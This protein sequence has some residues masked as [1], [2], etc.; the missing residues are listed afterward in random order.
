MPSQFHPHKL[1]PLLTNPNPCHVLLL[2]PIQSA[3]IGQRHF[4]S[5]CKELGAYYNSFMF[6]HLKLEGQELE[7][8]RKKMTRQM[9]PE[10]SPDFGL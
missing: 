8:N 4:K 2:T 1:E 10:R 3:A 5:E 7:S 9:D 6:R